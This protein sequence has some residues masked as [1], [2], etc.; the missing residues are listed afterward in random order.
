LSIENER[1]S[2]EEDKTSL[3]ED[4]SSL[5]QEVETLE[6]EKEELEQG[7]FIPVSVCSS[8]NPNCCVPR[9]ETP[10]R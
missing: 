6:Q 7:N 9:I 3:E 5:E 8:Y 4:K 2:L 1:S 10:A